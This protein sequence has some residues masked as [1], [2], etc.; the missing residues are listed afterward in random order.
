MERDWARF[1]RFL[2]HFKA[3]PVPSITRFIA[4]CC[5]FFTLIQCLDRPGRSPKI[6]NSSLFTQRKLSPNSSHL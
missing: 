4:G 3:L 5:Q 6:G 1:A 2:E